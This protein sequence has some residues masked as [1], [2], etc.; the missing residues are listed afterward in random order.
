MLLDVNE[1][2]ESRKRCFQETFDVVASTATC[3]TVTTGSEW[4]FTKIR[5]CIQ[6]TFDV[7]AS[8]ATCGTVTTGS[9]WVF[10]KIRY[11]KSTK[12]SPVELSERYAMDLG[13]A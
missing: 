10:T 11:C 12:K 8:T 9:E 7:V 4:V 3:G 5:Y 1:T 2:G 6:E 13:S